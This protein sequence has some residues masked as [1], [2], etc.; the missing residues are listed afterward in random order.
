[1]KIEY[2]TGNLLDAEERVVVQGCNAQ[3][4]MGKGLAKEVKERMPHVFLTYREAY[5][6]R[7]DTSRGLPLGTIVWAKDGDPDRLDQGKVVA[8][9]ITQDQYRQDPNEPTVHAD[10]EAIRSVVRSLDD[11]AVVS[12]NEK[13]CHRST[14]ATTGVPLTNITRIGF[15]LIGA[16]LAGGSWRRIAEIIE[17]EAKSFTPVVYLLEGQTVPTT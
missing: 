10:Y 13:F 3:G 5:E 9:A 12:Q 17:E 15:P 11:L 14:Y 16:G 1:M 4:V 8:N 2:K 6:T 7:D